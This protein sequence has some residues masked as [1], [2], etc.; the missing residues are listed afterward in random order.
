MA[1]SDSVS[2]SDDEDEAG[3]GPPA[4]PDELEELPALFFEEF[5]F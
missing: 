4:L 1:I 3:S 2:D 5:D